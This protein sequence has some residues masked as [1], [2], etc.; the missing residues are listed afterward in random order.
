MRRFA[1]A[2][3]VLDGAF[4]L[5]EKNDERFYEAELYRLKGELVLAESVDR[6]AAEE[7]FRRAIKTADRQQ[8]KAW[9][10]RATT[11]LARL[12]RSQ[13]R[14]EEAFKALRAAQSMFTE[15]F[16]TPDLADAAA[17]LESLTAERM[18]A[19]FAA[20]LKYVR[21]CIP[22]PMGGIVSMDWRYVP[23][24]TLGG[25]TIGYYWADND[26]LVLYLIDVT[27]HGLDSA[28]LSVSLT[29]VIRSGALSGTDLRRPDQV[30]AQLNDAFRG[31][32]HGGKFF[33]I[34]YGVYHAPSR[35]LTWAGGGHHPSVLLVPDQ[36]ESVVLASEGMMMGILRGES[37]PSQSCQIPAGARLLI[38][39]DGVFEIFRDGKAMWNLADCMAYL[40]SLAKDDSSIM[41]KL[42]EHVQRLRGSPHLEDDFSI[43]EARFG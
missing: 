20:G 11:S 14:R 42:L 43:I 2:K 29:N 3:A 23:A 15:G 22:P 41:D 12:W 16:T 4:R 36:P 34:W 27:G 40:K 8:S 21:D 25:D 18:Q 9:K 7:W 32:Q 1:E 19:E 5:V 26:H 17:L 13:G 37:Y 39:S 6:S 28:L 35:T 31:E 24:S 38:F 30:L 33:T 10:L